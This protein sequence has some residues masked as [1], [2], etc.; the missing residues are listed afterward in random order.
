MKYSLLVFALVS[1]ACGRSSVVGPKQ[2]ALASSVVG[3]WALLQ[4]CGGVA[5]HCTGAAN[6]PVPNSLV[7]NADGTV[8]QLRAGVKVAT[9]TFSLTPAATDSLRSSTLVMTPGLEAASDTL[10]LKFSIEGEMML[11]EPCCDR[12]V[13]SFTSTRAPD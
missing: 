12:L 11:G 8:D 2:S 4:G 10:S 13:Y 6:L 1:A 7:F 9:G 3:G 5:Y